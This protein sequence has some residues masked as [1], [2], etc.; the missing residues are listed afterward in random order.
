M[1]KALSHWLK[2]IFGS[3]Q[4]DQPRVA[5]LPQAE[6]NIQ[7]AEEFDSIDAASH[8]VPY[9]ENLL[10]RAR[11]QWQFG[12]WHSLANLDRETLQH[13]PDRAK[14][15]LLA[16]AGRL[17]IGQA[18]E[19][20]QYIRLAQDWGVSKKLLI[21]LL[22]AG[23]HN[24]L[25]RAAAMAGEQSRALQHFEAAIQTG[26]PGSDDRLLTQ[27]R[28]NEQFSQLGLLEAPPIALGTVRPAPPFLKQ[29]S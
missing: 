21:Q 27:A 4:P 16:A 13:H 24:S 25:G 20:R 5:S 11:T 9:D 6:S 7:M 22:A 28:T 19:A 2:Q 23:V 15:V 17:Q 29:D 1:F 12:D 8:L 26:T 10:E 3:A 18:S 14:L